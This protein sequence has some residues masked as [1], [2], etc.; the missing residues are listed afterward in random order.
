VVLL[1]ILGE[2]V[3]V[4]LLK[5]KQVV[6][7]YLTDWNAGELEDEIRKFR[8]PFEQRPPKLS[9]FDIKRASAIYDNLLAEALKMVPEG[10]AITIV[11]DGMLALLPFE[12]LVTGGKADWKKGQQG[13]YYPQGVSYLVDRNPIVYYQSL[14]ALTLARTLGKKKTSGERVLVIADPVFQLADARLQ[15][16]KPE[17]KKAD[18]ENDRYGR[19]MAAMEEDTMGC[20]APPSRLPETENLAKNL[21]NLYGPKCDAYTGLD[22]TKTTF[23]NKV[24]PGSSQYQSIVFATHGYAGNKIPGIMEPVLFLTMVPPGTDGLLTMSEVAGLKL[25]ADIACLTA[26]QTGVG[27]KLAGEGIMSMGRAFQCAGTK[28][29]VMSLWSVA[30][31]SSVMFMDEFFKGL[32]EGKGRLEAFTTARNQ[33]VKG[34]FENPFFWAAFVLVGEGT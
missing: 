17:I 12:A 4:R 15:G 6:K 26:C 8:Q 2:S 19:L 23:L 28:S 18:K 34:G 14:T 9:D 32:K 16:A 22:S 24:A 5:G 13:H 20:L 3:G 30:E 31:D 10:N 29:V 7:A 1:D 25:N 27:V 11:P 21:A 33:L